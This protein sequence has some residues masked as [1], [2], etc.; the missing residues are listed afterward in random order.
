MNECIHTLTFREAGESG[1]L[2]CN[3]NAADGAGI[4]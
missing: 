1:Y 3:P 4:G 2:R